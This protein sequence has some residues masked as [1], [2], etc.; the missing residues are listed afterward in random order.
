M[1]LKTTVKVG[2][3]NNLS[4]ARYC[5]GM[6]VDILGFC[7]ETEQSTFVEPTVFLAIREWL[8][9][10][11]YMAEFPTYSAVKIKQ[12]LS[13]YEEVHHLQV[14]SAI[15]LALPPQSGASLTISV[16][17]SDYQS[18]GDIADVLQQYHSQVRFFVLE[19]PHDSPRLTLDDALRLAKQYPI[20]LGFGV[21]AE[22]ALSLVEDSAIRG[23]ALKGSNEIKPGY[24]DF[25]DLAEILEVL[26]V[27]EEY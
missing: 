17:A 7:L 27:D 16:S 26:E 22:N 2:S 14:G 3:I 8:S 10:V 11:E 12:T 13:Q 6:G 9:G 5:A 25:D 15:D 24:K 23:I 20:L 19:N 4:D 21:T 18:L 1:A